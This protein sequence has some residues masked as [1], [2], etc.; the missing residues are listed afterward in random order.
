M[1]MDIRQ[2][3]TGWDVYGTDGDKLGTVDEVGPN[4]VLVKKG[5]IFRKDVYVPVTAIASAGDGRVTLAMT[6]DVASEQDWDQPPA[7]EVGNPAMS[8]T[9]SQEDTS[10]YELTQNQRAESP[11]TVEETPAEQ[12]EGSERPRMERGT[13]GVEP[14]GPAPGSMP[15]GGATGPVTSSS[16]QPQDTSPQTT[17]AGSPPSSYTAPEGAG[18]P[19]EP[20]EGESSEYVPTEGQGVTPSETQAETT[21]T[22]Y[23]ATER[24]DTGAEERPPGPADRAYSTT[25]RPPP[26][27]YTQTTSDTGY[28]ESETEKF[29]T[30]QPPRQVGEEPTRAPMD[31]TNPVLEP[32]ETERA[33]DES[34]DLPEGTL[35]RPETP[36]EDTQQSGQE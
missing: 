28:A 20:M 23:S 7:T 11:Q 34:S 15:V 5:L 10:D 19:S 16:V 29:V 3:Q 25:H 14:R 9:T 35:L 30:E 4:Y 18:V 31:E 8:P 36:P 26:R 24:T 21:D 1:G 32:E 2:V 13:G 6:K 22:G 12:E 27:S 33:Q 17:P